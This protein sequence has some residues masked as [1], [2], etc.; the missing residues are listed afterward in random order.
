MPFDAANYDAP[1]T[2]P[3][4]ELLEH[5]WSL[6][7]TPQKWCRCAYQTADGRHCSLGALHAVSDDYDDPVCYRAVARLSGVMGNIVVFNDG[8]NHAKL[9]AAWQRAIVL[10]RHG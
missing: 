8:S 5:A 4:T 1:V 3:V 6:I 2:N 9:A 10:S 7:D